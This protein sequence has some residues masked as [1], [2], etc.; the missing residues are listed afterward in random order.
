VCVCVC[1][2][3]CVCVFV[4]VCVVQ[5]G[6]ERKRIQYQGLAFPPNDL[7]RKEKQTL[8]TFSRNLVCCGNRF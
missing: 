4:C 2:C 5:E 7:R 3:L 1:V 8:L 6:R